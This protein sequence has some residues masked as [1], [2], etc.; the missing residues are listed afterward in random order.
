MSVIHVVLDEIVALELV[1]GE[2]LP[3]ERNLAEKCALSRTSIRNA[4]KE[5][6][7]RRILEVKRGSGYFLSSQ[8]ALQQAVDGRDASWTLNRVLQLIVAR[9]YV[10]PQA[11]TEYR[12]LRHE[13]REHLRPTANVSRIL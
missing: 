13:L 5:L 1:E 7:S 6:Q 11:V 4:L 2:R 3:S 10:E 8:F 9:S 12:H